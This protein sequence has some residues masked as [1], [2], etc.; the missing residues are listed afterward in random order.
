MTLRFEYYNKQDTKG[1]YVECRITE[2]KAKF[3]A[4]SDILRIEG[5]VIHEQRF[6]K[7][8]KWS[9]RITASVGSKYDFRGI[10]AVVFCNGERE[11]T[12]GIDSAINDI[13][14]GIS[15]LLSRKR[16]PEDRSDIRM[17]SPCFHIDLADGVDHNN[18]TGTAS[19]N[20]S[21]E[22]ITCLPCTQ[23]VPVPLVAIDG[24]I[25]FA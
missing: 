12:T 1:G 17:V 3:V 16:G 4:W 23:I 18:G 22:F 10:I 11:T 14:K 25:P 19:C 24:N 2:A 21:N 9:N 7:V 15:T 8:I 13:N 5:T 20:C 6:R